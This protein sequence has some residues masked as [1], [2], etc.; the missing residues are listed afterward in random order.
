M[1]VRLIRV[2]QWG[3][4]KG[5]GCMIVQLRHCFIPGAKRSVDGSELLYARQKFVL[6]AKA[7]R[8]QAIDMVHIDY[9]GNFV[10]N[11]FPNKP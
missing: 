10:L 4:E 11:P 9:K 2:S 8:L 7:Y 5:F 3:P 6:V 1:T